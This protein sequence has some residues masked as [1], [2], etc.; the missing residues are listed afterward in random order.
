M[1]TEKINHCR[2][3]G[4]VL[5]AFIVCA[6]VI[7]L[8][9]PTLAWLPTNFAPINSIALFGG[10]KYRRAFGLVLPILVIWFSDLLLDRCY[11]GKWIVFYPNFYWQYFSYFLI[12]ILGHYWLQRVSTCRVLGATLAAALLF[13]IISNFGVWAQGGWYAPTFSGLLQ[14]YLAGIPFLKGSM[15]GDLFYAAVLFGGFRLWEKIATSS[16][17]A[18]PAKS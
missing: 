9:T 7:R 2:D 8:I 17:L 18:N 1:N 14:C 15:A 6:A 4:W 12:A 13:F 3:N 16:Q 5:A 10:A 11:F